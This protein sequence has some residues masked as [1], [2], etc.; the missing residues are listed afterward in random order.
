MDY[1]HDIMKGQFFKYT[2]SFILVMTNY[3]LKMIVLT[4][5]GMI[6]YK[7]HSGRLVSTTIGIYIA[8]YINSGFGLLIANAYL[9][10]P[11]WFP[12]G[13]YGKR[14]DFSSKWYK[15]LG[16]QFVNNMMFMAV[17]PIIEYFMFS[18][19]YHKLPKC[20]DRW[21]SGGENATQAKTIA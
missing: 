10:L 4:N 20:W 17:F 21:M 9:N 3:L 6:S 11:A 2:L 19:I 5:V 1:E 18:T 8:Q 7:R 15:I 14:V 13:K 12:I 16:P